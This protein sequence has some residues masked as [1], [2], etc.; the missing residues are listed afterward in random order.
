MVN[1]TVRTETTIKHITS[2]EVPKIKGTDQ[3]KE[4]DKQDLT[5]GAAELA[6]LKQEDETWEQ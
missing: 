2:K 5:K 1:Y 6:A 4:L 3:K